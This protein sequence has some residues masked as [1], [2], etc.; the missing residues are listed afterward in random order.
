MVRKLFFL[1]ALIGLGFVFADYA[2]AQVDSLKSQRSGNIQKALAAKVEFKG[3]AVT[4]LHLERLS[5]HYDF[6]ETEFTKEVIKEK[7][8]VYHIYW[9]EATAEVN[10]MLSFASRISNT[11]A[12]KLWKWTMEGEPQ[13][14]IAWMSLQ[15]AYIG[16]KT[17]PASFRLGLLE[18]D[19]ANEPLEAHITP[20]K[21]SWTPFAVATMG[22][23]KGMSVNVPLVGKRVVR[24]GPPN[25]RTPAGFRLGTDFTIAVHAEGTGRTTIKQE[26]VE[27]PEEKKYNWP[28]LDFILRFPLSKGGI[29]FEPLL[30]LRS[31]ADDDLKCNPRNGKGDWRISYGFTSNCMLSKKLS[32]GCG[33]GFSRFSND[34]TRNEYI[35]IR[36]VGDQI[37]EV[38]SEIKDNTTIYLKIRPQWLIGNGALI[39]E[40]KYS[41]FND[42]SVPKS[43]VSHYVN[44]S[45]MYF[46]RIRQ[47]LMLMPTLRVFGEF[48]ENPNEH[49]QVE[50]SKIRLCPQL[51]TVLVF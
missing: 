39:G 14:D 8:L 29:S 44:G 41:T 19:R 26:K 17:K 34:H 49:E 30:A 22:S 4:F 12:T 43:F 48:Y 25:L 37:E 6:P 16:V 32:V 13:Q 1:L 50:Y 20:R 11:N 2:H 40:V 3:G 18:V 9:L 51:L 36:I 47:G 23:L 21:T 35:G 33:L 42:K 46:M 38:F 10:E 5:E 31:H 27:P 45:V 15:Y 24:K 7:Q 28:S